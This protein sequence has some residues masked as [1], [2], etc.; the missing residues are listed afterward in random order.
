V[1]SWYFCSEGNNNSPSTGNGSYYEI[2]MHIFV[3][4]NELNYNEM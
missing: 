1:K 4:Y 2:K 3:K